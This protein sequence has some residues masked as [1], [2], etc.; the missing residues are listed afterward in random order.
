MRRCSSCE[1]EKPVEEFG[2]RNKAKGLLSS[3]CLICKREKDKK[4]NKTISRQNSNKQRMNKWRDNNRQKLLEYLKD[5]CC[6]D[7]SESDP[8]VLD[9]DHQHTKSHNISGM[10][11][12]ASW[13]RILEEITKCEIRCANCHR[14]RTAKQFGWFKSR[15]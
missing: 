10:L 3:Y 4:H 2:W 13:Q 7:C 15:S 6:I 14:R 12:H 8:V 5:K 1:R 9:F 11:L